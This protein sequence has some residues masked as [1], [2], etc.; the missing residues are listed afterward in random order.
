MCTV[1]TQQTEVPHTH[2]DYLTGTAKKKKI[3]CGLKVLVGLKA[4]IE[5]NVVCWT[6]GNNTAKC[7]LLFSK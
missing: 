7:C 3:I 5:Q 2:N 6:Q 4:T 1:L